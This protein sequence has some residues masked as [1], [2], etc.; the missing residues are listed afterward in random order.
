MTAAPCLVWFRQDL[1]L[2]DHPALS[3]ARERGGAIIPVFVWAPE[4]EDGWAPG[5]AGRFW[6]HQSLAALETEL[7]RCRSRLVL[8]AGDTVEEL[9]RLLRETGARAVYWNRRYE[10]AA[11]RQEERVR[12][13]L[14][15]ENVELRDFPGNLLFEPDELHTKA[16]GPFQVFTP[17]YREALRRYHHEPPLGRPRTL[18]APSR[19]PSSLRLTDLAL[20]PRVDWAGGIRVFW[21]FGERAAQKRLRE[22]AAGA[23][24]EY[25]RLHDRVDQDGTS[26]LSPHLHFGEISP[27]Q[28]WE[29]FQG[30]AWRREELRGTRSRGKPLRGV[31]SAAA[32]AFLRQLIWR[33]FAHH[34]LAHFPR[35]PD[36]PLRPQFAR[37]PWRKAARQLEAWQRGR[38]GYPLV[39][40]AMRQLWETGWMHNRARMV[41]GSFLVKDLLVRWQEGEA[42]FWDTLVD[43]D[44]A[45]NAF[46]WQW[47]AGCGADPAPFFRIFNPT[48]QGKKFDP[49]GEYVRRYVPELARLPE[50]YIHEPWTAP[51]DV[52]ARAGVVFGKTYPG[53]IMDHAEARDRALMALGRIK[54]M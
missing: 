21:E 48:L 53:P 32:A 8:R 31:L 29:A 41:V 27:H 34:V 25:E 14:A 44:L 49:E 1:R 7:A 22:F 36:Q 11:A 17:F 3:A 54:G 15:G 18:M 26:C 4:E 50:K 5:S 39:D 38:T 42:W 35:L 33:E 23:V 46:N 6:L 10:P 19:W 28:V 37:M 20:L 30:E 47:V 24:D 52:L 43:G 12:A 2:A 40:A 51:A 9:G 16:G 45:N 13:R